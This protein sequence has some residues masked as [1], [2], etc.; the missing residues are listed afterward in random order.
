MN[1]LTYTT[2]FPNLADPNLGVFVRNRL[3]HLVASGKVNARVVAPVGWFPFKHGIFGKYARFAS[4][5]DRENQDGL[6]VYHPRFPIVPKIGMN[7]TPDFL[8]AFSKRT[9]RKLIQSGFDIDLIDAHYF[10][11]DGVAAAKLKK[12]L[13][14]PLVITARGTDINLIPRYKKPRQRILY[15][16]EAAD[17]IIT[18]CAALKDALIDLGVD[19]SKIT[20]LRNGVD[21][22]MF[23]PAYN[24]QFLRHKLRMYNTTLLSVGRLDENKGHHLVIE[25]LAELPGI[26][27]VIAGIGEEE[28]ALR[29]L[30]SEHGLG[31]RVTFLGAVSQRKLCDYYAAADTLVLASSREG[32]ANVLLEAMACGTPVVATRVWG[33]PEV[34]TKP[35]AGILC[36]SRTV[37]SLAT[38]I[39]RL[40]TNYPDREATRRYAEQFSWDATTAGQLD[41]FN[42][43]ISCS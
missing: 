34:V 38:S 28:A 36:E 9:I 2:L 8:A 24:R 20:V 39:S 41:I 17:A 5:P 40:F 33:T 13:N 22:Q 11:P 14:K 42:H 10:Y 37:E 32:W 12:W 1:I 25:A 18:V 15:A 6:G 31:T 29:R 35:E 27:L 43:L 30:V 16:A 23:K 3:R 4:A 19:E 21:L 7:W 26:D